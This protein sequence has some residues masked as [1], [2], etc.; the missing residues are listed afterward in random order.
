M[1][2]SRSLKARSFTGATR[3]NL[4]DLKGFEPL[5]SS[6]PWKRAPNCATGPQT[7]ESNYTIGTADKREM[8]VLPHP[9]KPAAS[10]P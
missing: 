9:D 10:T 4:V 5:T 6:M 1:M 8:S 3:G 7:T 2:A